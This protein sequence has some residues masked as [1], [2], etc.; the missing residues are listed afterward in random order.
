MGV[1]PTK[2]QIEESENPEVQAIA[3]DLQAY[4]SV[5][6]LSQSPGG[7]LLIKGFVTDIVTDLDTLANGYAKLTMQD[8]I[9]LGA[10][11]KMKLDTVRVLSRAET[12]KN[13]AL[14]AIAEAL[15]E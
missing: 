6:A 4:S 9:A 10:S 1:K 8:F 14:D 15:Q 11:M 5:A 2:K 3:E 13:Y 7:K 12:N